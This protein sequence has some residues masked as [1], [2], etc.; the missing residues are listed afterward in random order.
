MFKTKRFFLLLLLLLVIFVVRQIFLSSPSHELTYTVTRGE[1]VDTVEA[2]GMFM[3]ALQKE[4][5]S[6]TKG[7]IT[8][9][10][11]VNNQEVKKGEPLFHVESTATEKEKITALATYQTAVS[12]LTTAQ[13]TKESL[14]AT[15]W[16]EHKALLDAQNAKNFQE[17]NTTNPDTD[18]TYTDL[19][20][21][22]L[23]SALVQA[24]KDFATAEKKYKE[25]DS[26]IVAAQASLASAKRVYDETKDVTIAAPVGGTIVN[27]LKKVGD[28]VSI[29]ETS[30]ESQSQKKP[31]LP[32]LMIANLA[33]PVI[34]ATVNESYIPRITTGQRVSVI[35]DALKEERFTGSVAEVDTIGTDTDGVVTYQVRIEF[36]DIPPTIRPKM[37][38]IVSIET[39]YK[40]NVLT[41]PNSALLTQD[42]KTYIKKNGKVN[43]L[44]AVT[45]GKRGTTKTEV[46]S[47]LEE[48]DVILA[49]VQ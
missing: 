4:I 41:V 18:D 49:N 40:S 42:G 39:L 22:S 26:A 27:L 10:Y 7:V 2:S 15:M 5:F 24:R 1:L 30:S 12:T 37:T 35:F 21:R 6:P 46:T 29:P 34:I 45:T 17:D 33:N 9:L 28:E 48:G 20:K 44:I 36:P 38:A 14:D 3:T 25:A 31:V 43:E 23:D 13:Q 19:E 11:V 47:G 32:V 16:T 8:Q